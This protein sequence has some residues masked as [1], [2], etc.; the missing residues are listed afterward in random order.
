MQLVGVTRGAGAADSATGNGVSSIDA[1]G[2]LGERL[3]YVRPSRLIAKVA[4]LISLSFVQ[5][6]SL[7]QLCLLLVVVIVLYRRDNVHDL[8][9][10]LFDC[11]LSFHTC[12]RSGDMQPS[13]VLRLRGPPARPFFKLP[14][15]LIAI[16]HFAHPPN[17]SFFVTPFHTFSLHQ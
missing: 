8:A 5:L 1:F 3:D 17:P 15:P 11:F 16:Y 7:A 14:F 9:F 4:A 13:T 12:C 10:T 6:S 2:A